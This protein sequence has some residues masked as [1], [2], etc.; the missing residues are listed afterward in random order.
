VEGKKVIVGSLRVVEL[1]IHIHIAVLRGIAS[2]KRT[3]NSNPPRPKTVNLVKVLLYDRQRIYYVGM[4]NPVGDKHNLAKIFGRARDFGCG[5]R[6]VNNA[7]ALSANVAGRGDFTDLSSNPRHM[8][9]FG[10]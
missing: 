9:D 2:G 3:K 6:T 10:K 7:W 8:D 1:H 4:L 5:D